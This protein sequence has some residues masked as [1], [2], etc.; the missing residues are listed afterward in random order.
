MVLTKRSACAFRFGERGGSFTD[1]TPLVASVSRNSAVNNGIPVM[2][3]VSFA[4]QEAFGSVSEIACHLA[5][6]EPVRLPGHSG[7]L[8][9]PTRQVD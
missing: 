8:H 7:D 6:P 5:H 3:Q 2:D 9:P 1:R 4:D